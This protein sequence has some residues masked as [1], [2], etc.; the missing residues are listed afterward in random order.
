MRVRGLG[1]LL[2]ALLALGVAGPARAD[3][4]GGIGAQAR[5]DLGFADARPQRTFHVSPRGN[6]AHPGT[7]E[8]PWRTL[9]HAVQALEPGDALLV[10][11]G[12]YT[13]RVDIGSAA[14]DG[15]PDAPI[16]VLAAPGEKPVLRGGDARG[17]F[18]LRLARSHWVVDGLTVR[19]A[20]SHAHGIRFEGA[21]HVVVRNSE[22][23]GGTGPAAVAF[24]GGAS[25]I[26]FLRNKVHDYQW[27]ARDSHGLLVLPGSA[28]ILIQGNE[29]WGHDG[30]SFQCQ[31]PDT[32]PEVGSTLP[33]DITVEDNRFHEDRENAVDLKTCE[34]VTIRGNKFFGYRP[35]A[36]APQGAAMVVHYSARRILIEGNRVWDS[37][38]GLSLGGN[39]VW[40]EQPVTDVIVRRNLVFDSTTA[41]KG[42]GDGL[43]VGTSRRVRLYHNT[44]AFLPGAGLKLGDGDSGPAESLEVLNNI[45]Y[46]SPVALDVRRAGVKG[47]VSERNLTFNPGG[48]VAWRVD[49]QRTSLEGWRRQSSQDRASLVADPRFPADPRNQDFV[50]GAGSPARDRALTL[51]AAS[52]PLKG[53]VCGVGPDLGFLEACFDVPLPVPVV[54]AAVARELRL[55][56]PAPE[57]AREGRRAPAA[58]PRP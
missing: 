10:H 41:N 40:K 22:V 50:P 30:D 31:G 43:R 15:R 52:M 11:G 18:M 39:L 26:G 5:P 49:G 24:F 35:A 34:R 16:Q 44:L 3:S 19:T 33:L 47:L 23:S 7:A 2:G 13:E 38:R 4:D 29:S 51:G 12:T 6:D 45:I 27:G 57:G 14:K 17:S 53:G 1:W 46:A 21:R 48:E 56:P 9:G 55:A 54:A 28:R 20:G 8:Q 37:G 58:S 32:T 36:T 42:S 25:D